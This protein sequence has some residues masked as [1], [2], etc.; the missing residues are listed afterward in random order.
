MGG[1]AEGFVV[2]DELEDGEV[3]LEDG[4]MP[5]TPPPAAPQ[6]N[7]VAEISYGM[8]SSYVRTVM[9]RIYIALDVLYIWDKRVGTGTIEEAM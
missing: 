6:S 1:F 2:V 3:S 5:P 7:H 9:R 8:T 4:E